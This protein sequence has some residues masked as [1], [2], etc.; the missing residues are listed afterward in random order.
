MKRAQTVASFPLAGSL[1]APGHLVN[2]KAVEIQPQSGCQRLH[3]SDFE[4]KES[5]MLVFQPIWTIGHG[6]PIKSRDRVVEQRRIGINAYGSEVACCGAESP[7][8]KFRGEAQAFSLLFLFDLVEGA[9][10]LDA[11]FTKLHGEARIG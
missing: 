9:G 10:L 4:M 2:K 5:T 6:E 11:Y 8:E 3:G 7:A 1:F